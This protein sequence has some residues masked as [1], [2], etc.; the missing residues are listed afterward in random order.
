MGSTVVASF[1]TAWLVQGI[2]EQ[3]VTRVPMVV[4][5]V[6]V[7]PTFAEMG[8]LLDEKSALSTSLAE[9]RQQLADREVALQKVSAQLAQLRRPLTAD[10]LSSTLQA[11]LRSGEV[12]VTGG[13]RLPDGKRVYAF[14]Q[15]TV[16]QTD[17]GDR[18]RV[19]VRIFKVSDELGRT[20]G[21]DTLATNAANTMQHGEVWIADEFTQVAQTL[22][23]T[24]G[25]E[26]TPALPELILKTGESG[27]M[28][29]GDMKIDVTPVVGADHQ[30]LE[31][32]VR[33]EQPQVSQAVLRAPH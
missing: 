33:V 4:S 9:V 31:F 5:P 19:G 30:A 6:V 20:V 2:R 29:A 27:Q 14:A 23:A 28:D 18:I 24:G 13:Y 8:R 7:G 12:V 1:A 11:E 21:L 25:A 16:E 3:R 10:V 17:H 22:T 26:A 15:P 32:E